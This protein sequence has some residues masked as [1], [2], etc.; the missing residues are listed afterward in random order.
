ME[1]CL[2]EYL[3]DFINF[4]DA[5]EEQLHMN[6]SD[7][8]ET[9]NNLQDIQH[10]I[11]F[12]KAGGKQMLQVYQIY[13]QTRQKRRIAKENI[14]QC[15]PIVEWYGKNRQVVQDL[16]AL[17]GKVRKIEHIQSNRIY[18]LRTDILDNVVSLSYLSERKDDIK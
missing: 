5:S 2:S 14:E 10:F 15:T 1:A 16:R 13:K 6:E 9:N 12:G 8:E 4:L 17:L 11:E 18:T 7:L 3:E